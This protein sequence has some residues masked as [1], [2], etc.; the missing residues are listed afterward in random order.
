MADITNPE[1]IKFT[2]EQVR[3]LAEKFRALKDM[4]DSALDKWY[5]SINLK[6]PNDASPLE[7]GRGPKGVSRLLG[8]DIN[9][10]MAVIT[11]FQTDLNAGGVAG[12]VEKP[13]VRA[14]QVS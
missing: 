6:V 10:M 13:C 9:S 11:A 14:K 8:T 3:P 4:C 1:A 2:N 7:D 12:V 5:G